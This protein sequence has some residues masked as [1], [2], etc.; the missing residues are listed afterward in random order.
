MNTIKNFALTCFLLLVIVAVMV[1]LLGGL[2]PVQALSSGDADYVAIEKTLRTYAEIEAEAIFTLDDSRLSEV[3]ANDPRGGPAND[4][5]TQAVRY[6]QGKP[7][8]KAEAIGLLD[9]RQALYA[10]DRKVK[11]LYDAGIASGSIITPTPEVR[12]PSINPIPEQLKGNPEYDPSLQTPTVNLYTVPEIKA[13]SEATGYQAVGLPP[14]RPAKIEVEQFT[15]QAVTVEQDLAHVIA[16]Y[17][18]ALLELTLVKKE[19]RWYLVGRR[20]LRPHRG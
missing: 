3:L 8:L 12:D 2:R 15:I 14:A 20:E 10:Y 19:G 5:E 18:Y 4:I 1:P 17:P 7:D 6:M 11:Q 13:L 16:D 9:I